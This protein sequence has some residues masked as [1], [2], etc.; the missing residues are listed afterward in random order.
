VP[1]SKDRLGPY[2]AG[3]DGIVQMWVDRKPSSAFGHSDG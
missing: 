2:R 1:F 3:K